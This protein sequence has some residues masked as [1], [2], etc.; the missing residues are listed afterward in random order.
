MARLRYGEIIII[1]DRRP[2][3]HF[4]KN[5]PSGDVSFNTLNTQIRRQEHFKLFNAEYPKSNGLIYNGDKV[6]L[7][8]TNGRFLTYSGNNIRTE[9]G[10]IESNKI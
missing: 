5:E 1:G 3:I 8:S 9:G 2:G 6:V 10:G 4:L 7:L